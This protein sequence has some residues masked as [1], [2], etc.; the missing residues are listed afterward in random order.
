VF[1]QPAFTYYQMN[2]A[3]IFVNQNLPTNTIDNSVTALKTASGGLSKLVLS[4]E[5]GETV[6]NIILK[7]LDLID[8]TFTSG[9]TY[10]DRCKLMRNNSLYTNTEITCQT[11]YDNSNWH[12]KLYEVSASQLDM[13]WWIQ[14]WGTFTS[15]TLSY[16]F[17][18]MPY[19]LVV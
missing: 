6:P 8:I 16:K 10:I 18:I 17:Q 9:L 15:A 1:S 11:Y 3:I 5:F 2:P 12:V 7:K 19:N 4:L 14:I 13:G